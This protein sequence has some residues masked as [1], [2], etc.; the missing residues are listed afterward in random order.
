MQGKIIKKS[1]IVHGMICAS[2]ILLAVTNTWIFPEELTEEQRFTLLLLGFSV[3]LWVLQPIPVGAGSMLILALMVLLP[4]LGTMEQAL[5][6]FM[7]PAVYFVI[8]LTIISGVLV[9]VK[10]DQ[11]IAK[12]FMKLSK[13]GVFRMI[14]ILPVIVLLL[15][16]L[17]PS[18]VARFKVLSPI[19]SSLNGL[20]GFSKHSIFHR[21]TMAVIGIMNQ[22]A[23]MIVFTGGGF[24]VLAYQLWND[25]EIGS[26]SWAEW[27][28]AMAVPLEAIMIIMSIFTWKY[29]T[30][31]SPGEQFIAEEGTASVN[32]ASKTETSWKFWVVFSS[33]LAMICLWI[34]TDS[35]IFP[36]LIPPLIL[37]A[38]YSIP[39]I[40]LI[41]NAS[42]RK[43]DWENFLMLGTSFSLGMVL[44]EN[45]TADVIADFL[46]SF[47][48]ETDGVILET[49]F[50]ILLIAIMRFFFIVPSAALIV[51]FPI[52]MSYAVSAGMDIRALS[53]LVIFSVGSMLIL[54]IHST[55]TFLA[56]STGII[57]KGQQVVIGSVYT[58]VSILIGF[59]AAL[60]YW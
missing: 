31:T 17:L 12:L 45:H 48:P 39:S 28:L 18:A 7:T 13:G 1:M 2:F 19:L 58:L 32:T 60:F 43:A 36:V 33:F 21:Y 5:A 40:G 53:L 50:I 47:L 6:G 30:Y 56:F 42:V 16:I 26:L 54:P 10:V 57:T 37:I 25:Y 49:V 27:F 55:T 35:E 38:F 44:S 14:V 4:I 9:D 20:F 8:V 22:H 59:L 52:V 11:F 24:P 15:P 23:T 34:F 29:L 3:Y 41:S 51:I 46:I